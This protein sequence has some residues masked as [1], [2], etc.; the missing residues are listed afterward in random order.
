[1]ARRTPETW[2][3]IRTV[4]ETKHDI[5]FAEL[6]RMYG[7]SGAMVGR[8]AKDEKWV[9]AAVKSIESLADANI[10]KPCNGSELGKRSPELLQEIIN[11]LALSGSKK[12][13]CN[14]VGISTKTFDRWCNEEPELVRQITVARARQLSKH[15]RVIDDSKDWKAHLKMLQV[16]SETKEQYSD[17]KK[18]EGPTIILNIHRDEVVIEQPPIDVTPDIESSQTLESAEEPETKRPGDVD[19]PK[20]EVTETATEPPQSR[21]IIESPFPPRDPEGARE[22]DRL[23]K[24]RTENCWQGENVSEKKA[25]SERQALEQRVMGLN[26]K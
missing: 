21:S 10:A 6:G 25:L 17:H 3:E 5:G 7:V 24:E 12:H 16:A 26:N 8:K 23:E 2:A 15:M 18:D 1:M 9:R 20:K 11:V 14:Q 13:A 22:R 4:Y 19:A